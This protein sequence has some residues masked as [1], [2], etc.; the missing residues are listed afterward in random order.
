MAQH[1]FA[2]NSKWGVQVAEVRTD[3]DCQVVLFLGDCEATRAKYPHRFGLKYTVSLDAHRLKTSLKMTNMDDTSSITPQALLHNYFKTD[4]VA[5]TEVSG[6]QGVAYLD[7]LTAEKRVEATNAVSFVGETD[8]VYRD[9][10]TEILEIGCRGQKG[11]VRLAIE[12]VYEEEFGEAGAVRKP[13]NPDCVIWNPHVAKAKAMSD[14]DN[15]GWK[16]MCCVEPGVLSKTRP[17]IEPGNSVV[18]TQTIAYIP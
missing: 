1:G 15:H 14:F 13:F 12:A 9:V 6:L 16:S 11:K 18:L 7:Q 10:N 3:G 5:E 2:R 8:R 17:R 4:E